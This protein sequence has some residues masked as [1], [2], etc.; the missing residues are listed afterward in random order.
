M[1]FKCDIIIK[2]GDFVLNE[3]IL[4]EIVSTRDEDI[5][6]EYKNYANKIDPDIYRTVCSFSNRLGG[7]I[8]IGVTDGKPHEIVGIDEKYIENM[9]REFSNV[10]AN[11]ERI[12]P[13]QILELE[14][15]K[16][17][18]KWVLAIEIYPTPYVLKHNKYEIYDRRVDGDYLINEN[19]ELVQQ[20]E[21]R[22]SKTETESEIFPYC[23][24]EDFRPDIIERA[25]QL[26]IS[27]N[28]NHPWKNMTNEQILKSKSLFRINPMT[29]QRGYTLACILLFGTDEL[30][31]SVCTGN[32]TDCLK[33][34]KDIDR[35]DDRDDIRTN[36]IDTYF[37]M[38]D[39]VHKHLDDKFALDE[40]GNRISVR[41]NLF[42]E[43]IANTIIHRE[44]RNKTVARMIIEEDKVVFENGCNQRVPGRIT[45]EN[46]EPQPRNTIIAKI[47][48]EM[49]LADELG[50]G[51][52]NMY[53][54]NEQYTGATPIL[55]DG[56]KFTTII[57]LIS[58]EKSIQIQ[59]ENEAIIMNYINQNGEISSRI[60]RELLGLSRAGT[61]KVLKKMV[62]NKQ[63]HRHGQSTATIYNFTPNK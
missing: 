2:V 60:A 44:Y 58:D 15:I 42:R 17:D 6:I 19:Q 25:R 63:I 8:I 57:P 40:E 12:T 56:D 55:T 30:I 26:A 35:Y 32:R 50:S 29:G 5:Q 1:G 41:N 3:Q 28:K 52:R 53:K 24:L 59:N 33:R 51:I 38:M 14:K 10:C 23:E 34:V 16:V 9:Q 20:M 27:N 31:M 54:Y 11:P 13:K 7:I 46:V 37:R 62:E 39:F 4:K 61:A 22:K 18:G 21:I 36:L 47:F 48:N 49:G 43:A 45:P